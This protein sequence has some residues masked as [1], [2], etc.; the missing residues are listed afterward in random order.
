MGSHLE[1]VYL[2]LLMGLLLSLHAS[3]QRELQGTP[4]VVFW[5]LLR[6]PPYA[7]FLFRLLRI[8]G[9]PPAKG[10]VMPLSGDRIYP[11]SCPL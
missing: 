5:V 8:R 9:Q 4:K 3:S 11:L 6:A 7:A 2:L 1:K 10:L